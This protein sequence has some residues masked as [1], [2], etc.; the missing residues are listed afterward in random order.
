VLVVDWLRRDPA[1]PSAEAPAQAHSP[2]GV[3]HG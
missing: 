3:A 2:E 1:P